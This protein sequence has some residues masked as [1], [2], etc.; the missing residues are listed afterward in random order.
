MLDQT[1]GQRGLPHQPATARGDGH[2]GLAKGIQCA[3][4][5]RHLACV[6]DMGG[7]AH[8]HLGRA[9]RFGDIVGA[10][11]G[12]GG[13]HVLAFG[14]AGHEHDGDGTGGKRGF[15][16]ASHLETIQPRHDRVQQ[17]DI[18]QGQ[19]RTLQGSFA[20]G[21]HQYG[22]ASVVQGVVQQG[23]VVRLVVYDQHHV[24]LMWGNHALFSGC[25]PWCSSSRRA[26]NW[27]WRTCSPATRANSAYAVSSAANLASSLRR[28][29]T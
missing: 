24:L 16:A 20:I 9:Q 7:N 21:S 19:P 8:Q 28:P 22:V 14:Q 11:C 13:D 17:D 27:N 5:L 10:A 1:P 3:A 26:S 29:R 12:K 23:E 18:G 25:K 6:L 15:Q 4:G 2:R